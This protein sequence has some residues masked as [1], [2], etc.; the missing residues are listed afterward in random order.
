MGKS[1][2]NCRFYFVVVPD[3][4]KRNNHVLIGCEKSDA[5]TDRESQRSISFCSLCSFL[6]SVAKINEHR[7]GRETLRNQMGTQIKHRCALWSNTGTSPFGNFPTG[8]S[9]KKSEM[10]YLTALPSP[11]NFRARGM[12]S[13]RNAAPSLAYGT[14]GRSTA[15]RHSS[16]GINGFLGRSRGNSEKA[17]SLR[18][19]H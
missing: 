17:T 12:K 14:K 13:P 7:A 11:K 16:K 1:E 9:E 6:G 2:T 18:S 5:C 3:V 19:L 10:R 4:E 15:G 8:P